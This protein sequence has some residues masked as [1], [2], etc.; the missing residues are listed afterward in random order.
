MGKNKSITESMAQ[1]GLVINGTL[2]NPTILAAVEPFGYSEERIRTEGLAMYTQTQ[3]E[4]LNFQKEYGEQYTAYGE[5]SELWDKN[6]NIYMPILKLS[7]IALK[8]QSGALRSLRATGSRNRSITG[9]ISDAKILYGNLLSQPEFL[10]TMSRFG[11]TAATL[12]EAQEQ[13]AVLERA[14]VKYFKE[15]GEA[16]DQTV[17]RDRMYDQLY[18]WYSDFRAV[19]R[20]AL[21][22]SEQML[23]KLGIVVKRK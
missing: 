17:K 6:H 18:D 5:M 13:L 15:K 12:T 16:Q 4:F 2:S 23:E 21:N 11:V 14:H 20:I 3:T 7:R 22:D 1:I 19:L 8:N 10:D 9:F